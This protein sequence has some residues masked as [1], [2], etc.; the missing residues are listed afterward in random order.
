MQDHGQRK[1]AWGE[2]AQQQQ[3]T[4]GGVLVAPPHHHTQIW[5]ARQ[6]RRRLSLSQP[7]T[8][9]G[10]WCSSHTSAG[11]VHEQGGQE[12][13]I[14]VS[15]SWGRGHIPAVLLLLGN[16]DLTHPSYSHSENAAPGGGAQGLSVRYQLIVIND[17]WGAEGRKHRAHQS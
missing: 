14:Y 9:D 11:D 2:A 10:R 5:G 6:G 3:R 1:G 8:L 17:P 12:G 13:F 15:S 7:W 4:E 16:S